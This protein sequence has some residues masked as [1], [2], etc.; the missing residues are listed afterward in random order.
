MIKGVFQEL[1]AKK[2]ENL[3]LDVRNNGGGYGEAADEVLRYLISAP[4]FPYK[5]EYAVVKKIP[6]P[7]HYEKDG[8]FKHFR[9]QPLVK[10]GDTYHIKNIELQRILP[11]KASYTGKLYVLQNAASASATGTFL[12][13]VK[14]YTNAT[15]IGEEAGGNPGETTANDLLRLTL[16]NSKVRV[17]IPVLRSVMNLSFD[18]KGHGVLPDYGAVPTI[19]DLLQRRDVALDLAYKLIDENQK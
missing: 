16:P 7:K 9:R 4:I 17:T 14:S 15:F 11:K 6:N 5:D 13:L 2:I 19:Y 12:G 3:I 1:K 10:K 18:H 8:F